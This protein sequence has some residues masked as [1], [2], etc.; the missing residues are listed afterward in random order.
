M[1]E[2]IKTN[3]KNLIGHAERIIREEEALT[4]SLDDAFEQHSVRIV[5]IFHIDG[6][7]QR[8]VDESGCSIQKHDYY[9]HRITSYHGSIQVQ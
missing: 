4:A 6:V 9:K 5:L 7:F 3:E 2:S 1:I 8:G